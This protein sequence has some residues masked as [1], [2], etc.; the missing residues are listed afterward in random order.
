MDKYLLSKHALVILFIF[1][2]ILV[3][4]YSLDI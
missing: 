3:H 1:V 2:T 4:L